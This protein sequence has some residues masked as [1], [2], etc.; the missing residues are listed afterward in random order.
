M[1]TCPPNTQIGQFSLEAVFVENAAVGERGGLIP[2]LGPLYNLQPRFGEPALFGF[3][4]A[5][6]I[7]VLLEPQLAWDSDYHESF[8]I[9]ALPA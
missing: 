5:E 7:F 1:P 9:R 3:V 4:A 2:A 8:R 6:S